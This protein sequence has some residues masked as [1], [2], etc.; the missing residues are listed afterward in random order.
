MKKEKNEKN[1]SRR[2]TSE[3]TERGASRHVPFERAR[4]ASSNRQVSSLRMLM[5][6]FYRVS[7][8][9]LLSKKWGSSTLR[10]CPG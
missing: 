1:H 3:D 9:T 10:G 4:R 6:G 2:Y 7:K 8:I 5:C